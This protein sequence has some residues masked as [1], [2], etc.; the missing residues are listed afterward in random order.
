[1]GGDIKEKDIIDVMASAWGLNPADITPDAEFNNF[2]HWDSFGHVN[3]LLGLEKKY[4]I[5]LDY[6][7]LTELISIPAIMNYLNKEKRN[8]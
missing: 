4:K 1:M 2:P 8:V 6:N 3:L 5:A 7:I